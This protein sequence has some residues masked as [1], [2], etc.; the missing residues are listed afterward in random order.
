MNSF[1]RF[2][3]LLSVSCLI[4]ATGC[5]TRPETGP[6]AIRVRGTVVDS[7][8]GIPLAG[9]TIWIEDHPGE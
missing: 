8:S 2:S 6:F 9:A 1:M 7:I 3:L 4:T 5:F